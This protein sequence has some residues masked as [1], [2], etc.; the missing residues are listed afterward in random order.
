M[1]CLKIYIGI[2]IIIINITAWLNNNG[3]YVSN[4]SEPCMS[5]IVMSQIVFLNKAT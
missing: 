4:H 2:K 5:K 1:S 3:L